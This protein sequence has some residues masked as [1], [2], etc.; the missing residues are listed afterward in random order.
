L[1]SIWAIAKALWSRNYEGTFAAISAF[2][3]NYGPSVH[4]TLV[5][6]LYGM[7]LLFKERNDFN[8]KVH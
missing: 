6:I 4:L 7:E 2:K 8:W 3:S 1:Q 5:E